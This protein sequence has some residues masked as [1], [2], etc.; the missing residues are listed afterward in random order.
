LVGIAIVSISIGIFD[1]DDAAAKVEAKLSHEVCALLI[2]DL[3]DPSARSRGRFHDLLSNSGCH[4]P[5]GLPHVAIS[6]AHGWMQSKCDLD[7]Y[8]YKAN[9]PLR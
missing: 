8:K 6:P 1:V 2:F 7:L 3:P 5:S 4:A 9:Q